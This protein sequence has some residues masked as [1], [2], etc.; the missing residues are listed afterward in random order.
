MFLYLYTITNHVNGRMY[1]GITNNFERRCKEHKSGYGSLLVKRAIKKYGLEAFEFRIICKGLEEYIK[2]MEIRAIRILETFGPK[3]YNLTIGGE[4]S[5]GIRPSIETRRKIGE[6]HR[7]KITSKE[8]RKKM[9]EAQ[10]GKTHSLETRRKISEGHKNPSEET[11][12]KMSEAGRNISDETRRKMSEAHKGKTLSLEHRKKIGD[13]HK[14]KKKRL[15][16]DEARRKM[17]EAH[18]GK[19]L[20]L[21]HRKKLSEI[22]KGKS[23]PSMQCGKH[24]KAIILTVNGIKYNCIKSAAKA[25]K[26]CYMTMWSARKKVGSNVFDYHP[27]RK[28]SLSMASSMEA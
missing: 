1:V 15:H 24:P 28:K 25:L 17:S 2:E 6:A 9:S 14:G 4:G 21:E 10:K 23:K 5:T 13:A 7:G 19:T 11:R 20:S 3:G 18:K 12:R 26:V 8:T 16:S 22:R 27:K